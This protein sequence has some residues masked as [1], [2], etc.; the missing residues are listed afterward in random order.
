TRLDGQ[1]TRVNFT[2]GQFVNKGQLLA[3]IDPRPYEVQLAQAQAQLA[4]DQATLDNSKADLARYQ[5]LVGRGVI[6]QQQA[7][8]QA[9]AVAQ[10]SAV[11]RVDEAQI[12]NAKL[13]LTYCH[14]VAPISGRVGLRQVD[15]GNLVHASD[16]NGIVVITQVQPIGVLFTIPEDSL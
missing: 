15:P 8:T 3:E 5:Y 14:I 6:P 4:R 1:L 10:N 11:I 16:A 7:D 13:Q 2:E 9:A 12:E